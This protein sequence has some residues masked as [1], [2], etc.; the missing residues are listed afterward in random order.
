MTRLAYQIKFLIIFGLSLAVLW[1]IP[2]WVN[3]GIDGNLAVRV[4]IAESA[5]QSFECMIGVAEVIRRRG[6]FKG[7]SVMKID[8]NAFY[9]KQSLPIREKAR[10]AWLT[11]RVSNLSQGATHFENVKAF[12]PPPWESEMIKTVHLDDVQFYKSKRGR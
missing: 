4:I 12:G 2:G 6:N 7:F 3:H 8:L 9:L 1:A 5:N 11:S 10:F